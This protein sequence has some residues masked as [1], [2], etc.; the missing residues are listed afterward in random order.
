MNRKYGILFV[1]AFLLNL[2]IGCQ[3]NSDSN[4]STAQLKQDVLKAACNDAVKE[5]LENAIKK[6]ESTLS[7]AQFRK[8]LQN[9]KQDLNCK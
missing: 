5:N 7:E 9:M 4:L 3:K 8:S 1:V 2:S 6:Q